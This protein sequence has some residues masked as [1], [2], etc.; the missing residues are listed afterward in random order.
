MA[1]VLHHRANIVACDLHEVCNERMSKAVTCPAVRLSIIELSQPSGSEAGP[2]YRVV[3]RRH[4]SARE[5]ESAPTERRI[6][7]ERCRLRKS[8]SKQL[9]VS[10]Y[11]LLGPFISRFGHTLDRFLHLANVPPCHLEVIRCEL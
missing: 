2:G 9:L 11:V 4:L 5:Y 3:K 7:A 10:C 6:R 8:L 1:A